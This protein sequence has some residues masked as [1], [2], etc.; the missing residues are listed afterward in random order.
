[1]GENFNRAPWKIKFEQIKCYHTTY[2]LQITNDLVYNV[3][4]NDLFKY[5]YHSLELYVFIFNAK[6]ITL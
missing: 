1:M 4:L 3:F 5:W 2:C 6:K